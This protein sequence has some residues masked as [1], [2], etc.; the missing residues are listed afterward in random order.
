[1]LVTFLAN[2]QCCR[3]SL[4]RKFANLADFLKIL[5]I[6]LTNFSKEKTIEFVCIYTYIDIDIDVCLMFVD[7]YFFEDCSDFEVFFLS[8][9]ERSQFHGGIILKICLSV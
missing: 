1:M 6:F 2:K 5:T 9:L 4:L 3:K 7:R 8:L